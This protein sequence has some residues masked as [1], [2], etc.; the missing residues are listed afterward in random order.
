MR[1]APALFLTIVKLPHN[2]TKRVNEKW[3]V[4]LTLL[5]PAPRKVRGEG[6][7]LSEGKGA[8]TGGIAGAEHLQLP[9]WGLSCV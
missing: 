4:Q 9:G 5:A 1:P 3:A 2:S 6:K 7:S 8:G